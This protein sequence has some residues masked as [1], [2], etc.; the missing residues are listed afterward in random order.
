MKIRP[1]TLHSVLLPLVLGCGASVKHSGSSSLP[2]GAFL[3]T[4]EQI[5]RSGARTAWQVIRQ[6][7]PMLLAEEDEN[8]RPVK[9]TRR[10][11]SSFKLNDAP[12]VMIDDVRMPDFRNLDAVD[13]TSINTI[14][15]LDGIEGTT[16]Y[17][18]NSVSGVILI[19]TKTGRN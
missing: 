19:K 3:I 17:G 5:E 6:S 9:L 14:Y 13:A 18:T 10:G 7:A 2:P 12:A 4:A 16:Y 1:A 11:R 8:G 15:I